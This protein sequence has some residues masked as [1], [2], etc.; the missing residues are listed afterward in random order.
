MKFITFG[1]AA[2]V[3][4][5][6]ATHAQLSWTHAK[7]SALQTLSGICFGNDRWVA[8]GDL[9]TTLISIDGTQWAALRTPTL[10]T[11]TAVAYSIS[12]PR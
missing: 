2:A 10:R 4:G 5:V 7:S 3:L 1:I 12:S 8:V 11:L 9:G 6:G